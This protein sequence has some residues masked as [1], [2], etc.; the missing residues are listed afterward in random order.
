MPD[1]TGGKITAIPT[2]MIG[3]VIAGARNYIADINGAWFGP[4]QPIPPL[5]PAGTGGRQFDYAYGANLQYNPRSEDS[6]AISFEQL[7]A[8]ADNLPLLRGAIETRKDQLLNTDWA[9]KPRDANKK[10]KKSKKP[11]AGKVDDTPAPEDP[12]VQQINDFLLFPDRENTFGVWIRQLVEEMLV[13]DAA[14]I[15]P[16]MTRGGDVYSLDLVDGATIKRLINSDG[17]TPEAPDPAY[18]QIL[19]GVPA[20]DFTRDELVYLPRNKRVHKFYGYSPVEQIV[21]T[22]NIALR[23]EVS[24]LA[25]YTEGTLPDSFI[26]LPK[27][28]TIDQVK[29]F[30]EYFDFLMSGNLAERRKARFIPGDSKVQ[31]VKQPPLK[32]QYDEWLARVVCWALNVTVSPLVSQVNRATGDTLKI[33]ATEE[34]KRPTQDWLKSIFNIIIWKY[35]GFTDLEFVWEDEDTTDVVKLAQSREIYVKNGILGVDD[36]LE[37]MGRDG[38]GVGHIIITA[39]GAQ[40]LKESVDK[41]LEDIK[42]PPPPPVQLVPH[43]GNNQNNPAGSS[44]GDN[45]NGNSGANNGGDNNQSGASND[46]GSKEAGKTAVAT[47]RKA[48][49]SY[50]RSIIRQTRDTQ[51]TQRNPEDRRRWS[52]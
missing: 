12:R 6:G 5:A 37:D 41:A 35:F 36:V 46:S 3:R 52:A 48:L 21:L 28:W 29:A 2:T 34:G 38:I 47:F 43:N 25:Y 33:Q 49:D 32:D 8:L 50:S 11:Q 24:T 39:M 30:Q 14:T 23:R 45:R 40:P 17:R 51:G 31:D 15:Y 27:E 9:I 1:T 16:R 10:S 42:N 44:G 4:G 19:H 22:V 26:N 13:I 18:Q 20:A 7:R